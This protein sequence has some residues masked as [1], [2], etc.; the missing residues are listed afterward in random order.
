MRLV[1]Y[2]VRTKDGSE[3]TTTSHI[4]ATKDGNR[5]TETFLTD[6]SNWTDEKEKSAE[7]HRRKVDEFLKSKR[8]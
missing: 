4:E 3:F 1:N 7:E 2:K 8:G 5:I 6:V